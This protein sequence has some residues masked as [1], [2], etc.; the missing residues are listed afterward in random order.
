VLDV[1]EA[2]LKT[3]NVEGEAAVGP[4]EVAALHFAL[5]QVAM[6]LQ[7]YDRAVAGLQHARLDARLATAFM[8]FLL[9]STIWN[10]IQSRG[11]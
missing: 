2:L 5:A 9:A 10:C 4:H 11:T 1:Y 8:S 3:E 6:H 7:D